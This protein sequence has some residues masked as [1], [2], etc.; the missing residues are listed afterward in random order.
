MPESQHRGVAFE[1]ATSEMMLRSRVIQA[2]EVA[3]GDGWQGLVEPPRR[4]VRAAGAFKQ[5]SDQPR[6]GPMVR[7]AAVHP[8]RCGVVR[9]CCLRLRPA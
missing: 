9:C 1:G 3:V 5:A 2:L 4:R 7:R 8:K 6:G